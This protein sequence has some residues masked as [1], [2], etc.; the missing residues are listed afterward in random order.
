MHRI[1]KKPVISH[2][3]YLVHDPE[4]KAVI[5]DYVN[6]NLLPES[7]SKRKWYELAEILRPAQRYEDEDGKLHTQPQDFSLNPPRPVGAKESSQ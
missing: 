3:N 5:G 7:K 2:V 4:Q 6:I 1:L